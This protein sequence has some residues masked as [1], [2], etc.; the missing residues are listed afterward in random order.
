MTLRLNDIFRLPEAALAGD[1][2]IPKTMLV[3]QAM[4]TKHE[5]KVLDKVR[6][7]EHFATVQKSTTRIPPR[8]DDEYDIQGIIVLRCEMAGDSEAYAEVG[9]L[10]HKCFPNPTVIVFDG[11]GSMCV[12]VAVTRK[13]LAEKGATVIEEVQSS[14]RFVFGEPGYGVFLQ[15]LEFSRLE[16]FDLL[17][18]LQAISWNVRMSRTIPVMGFFPR[19]RQTDREKLAGL[20]AKSDALAHELKELEE[21]RR[22]KDVSLNEKAKLRMR[23]KEIQKERDKVAEEIKE[24]CDGRD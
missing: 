1:K 20:M 4:L 3:S 7:L 18:Y 10:L 9:R 17:T 19:C 2:R 21:A 6:R 12:S 11:G 23:G 14:G 13:S 22:D 15:S 16:Q 8:V 5:Q 24:M